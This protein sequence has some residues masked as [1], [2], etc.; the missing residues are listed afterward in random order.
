MSATHNAEHLNDVINKTA[1]TEYLIKQSVLDYINNNKII[2]YLEGLISSGKS[3]LCKSINVVLNKYNIRNT[4]YPEPIDK[5]L[6]NLFYSNPQKYAFTFQS[7]V[8]RERIHV[9]E[10]AI[11]YLKND[12]GLAII[13]RSR[14]G[15]CSFGIMH[16]N[17]NNISLAEFEVYTNLIKSNRLDKYSKRLGIDTKDQ[18]KDFLVYL[19]CTPEKSRERV[20]KRGNLDEIENCTIEYLSNLEMNYEK[21]LGND[22]CNHVEQVAID[23][24]YR[25]YNNNIIKINYNDDLTIKD[26]GLIEETQVFNILYQI[27]TCIKKESVT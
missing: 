19:F 4:N 23:E 5:S 8:I 1:S 20:I 26:D 27:I 15:D 22:K 10:D 6:L 7:I 25:N 14:F 9:N 2:I 11:K 17:T 12:N 3:S 24:I 21:V 18:I 13:D 16:Y